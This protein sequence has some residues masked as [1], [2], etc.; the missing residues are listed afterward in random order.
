MN[1][2][3]VITLLALFLAGITV[4]RLSKRR[5]VRLT[6]L[7]VGA[8]VMVIAGFFLWQSHRWNRGFEQIYVGDSRER[9]R[10]LMGAPTKDTDATNGIS[11]SKWFDADRVQDCTEQYWYYSFFTSECWRVAFY[12]QGRVLKTNHYIPL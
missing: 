12:A 8:V 6:G 9:V 1:L 11:D 2:I 5:R 4:A 10:Q 3:S 7:A